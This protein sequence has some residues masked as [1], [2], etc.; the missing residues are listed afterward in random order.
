M[1]PIDARTLEIFRTVAET[2]SATRAAE[3]LNSTQP[4]ITRAVG[5][6]EKQCG[7]KL[8]ER[9]RYG[10]TL[11]EAGSALLESV[12]RSFAGLNMVQEAIGQLRLGLPGTLRTVAIPVVAEGALCDLL[13]EFARAHPRVAI[14]I[15]SAHPQTVVN[16]ILTGE[17]DLGAIIG[18]PPQG[19]D[20]AARVIGER[21]MKIAVPADHRLANR[22]RIHFREL[23]GEQFVMMV[24][25]HNIRLAVETMM[26]DFG[27]RPSIAHE[28]S[29]QRTVVELARRT[30][31]IGFADDE[32]IDSVS[33]SD[34]MAIELDPPTRWNINLIYRRDRKQSPV[35]ETFLQWLDAR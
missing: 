19:F 27:V 4:S 29:T 17:V 28:V 16:D 34:V 11:T 5:A 25:P 18:A 30:G 22:D 26:N 32:V 9:G 15:K 6:F 14:N 3:R 21:R 12:D 23:H 35:C 33:R 1:H 10:M 20:L 7:F 8:F 24:Q 31:A 2:G 13:A